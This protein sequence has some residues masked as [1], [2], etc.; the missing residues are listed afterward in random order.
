MGLSLEWSEWWWREMGGFQEYYGRER[1]DLLNFLVLGGK[2]EIMIMLRILFGQEGRWWRHFPRRVHVESSVWGD[3]GGYNGPWM[4]E[5]RLDTCR[6]QESSWKLMVIC[7]IILVCPLTEHSPLCHKPLTWW[8]GKGSGLGI[9]NHGFST[10]S[11]TQNSVALRK[12]LSVSG[13]LI[14]K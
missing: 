14:C 11:V 12:S 4:N 2:T 10:S 13:F 7:S 5:T 8:K 6:S 1:E 9:R 3:V